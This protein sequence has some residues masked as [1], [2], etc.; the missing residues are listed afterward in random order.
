M[1]VCICPLVFSRELR[2][3]SCPIDSS[4]LCAYA[5]AV[6]NVWSLKTKRCL[7]IRVF[8]PPSFCR[9]SFIPVPKAAGVVCVSAREIESTCRAVMSLKMRPTNW[10]VFF[11]LFV[12]HLWFVF[13]FFID[14][15]E[16]NL[17]LFP[18]QLLLY[19]LYVCAREKSAYGWS[20]CSCVRV[21]VRVRVRERLSTERSMK[22]DD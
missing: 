8:V 9:K 13:V 5:R 15:V 14:F 12:F 16:N 2:C 18:K 21:R 1:Y 7:H 6:C 10:T 17:L 11:C 19:V 3:T 4:Q 20:S 22:A